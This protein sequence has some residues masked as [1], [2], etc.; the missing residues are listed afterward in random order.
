M[1]C[2]IVYVIGILVGVAAAIIDHYRHSY[3]YSLSDGLRGW[4]LAMLYF[5][6]S[7]M[8]LLFTLWLCKGSSNSPYIPDK[9]PGAARHPLIAGQLCLCG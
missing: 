1:F 9:P 5:Y 3:P 2:G 6:V 4:T 8:A 7:V